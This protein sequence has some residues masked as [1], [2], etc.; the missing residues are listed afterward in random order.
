MPSQQ[1]LETYG[2]IL[3]T[4][5]LLNKLLKQT[6]SLKVARGHNI[7]CLKQLSFHLLEEKHERMHD[8][9]A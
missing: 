3:L 4:K 8:K 5:L 7:I 6:N 1:Q 9:L 2:S